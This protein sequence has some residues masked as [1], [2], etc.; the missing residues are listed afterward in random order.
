VEVKRGEINKKIFGKIIRLIINKL[1]KPDEI[2][3]QSNTLT[4]IG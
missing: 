1:N 2:S 3:Y 4:P